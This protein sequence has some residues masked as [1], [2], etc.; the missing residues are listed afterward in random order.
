MS[1]AEPL[2]FTLST[3][4]QGLD[5]I[6][7]E[8]N[9]LSMQVAHPR[10]YQM[11]TWY[12][13]YLHALSLNERSV[14]FVTA[15]R[16]QRLVAMFPL[17]RVDRQLYGV[18]L[19]VLQF[20]SHSHMPLADCLLATAESGQGML[21]ALDRFLNMETTIRWDLMYFSGT[22]E[23]S[24]MSRIFHN[25]GSSRARSKPY[26]KSY[27]IAC[28]SDYEDS[29][30]HLSKR[31]RRNIARLKRKAARQGRLEYRTCFQKACMEPFLEEFLQVEQD[32]WKGAG[33][34]AILCHPCLVAFYRR[35]AM[36]TWPVEGCQINLLMLDGEAVAGQ[37]GL[38]SDGVLNL[39]KVGYRQDHAGIG[40][41]NLLLAG[42]LKRC[43]QMPTL[44][45]ISFVTAPAW[46]EKWRS[47]STDVYSHY[48]F[49]N[50]VAGNAGLYFYRA[51][52]HLKRLV[53]AAGKIRPRRWRTAKSDRF[54]KRAA[55]KD[56]T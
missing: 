34:T 26:G 8:W 18:P 37:F 33:N 32:G 49:N 23:D 35:L 41:G 12:G 4:L 14:H 7:D 52:P 21:D 43:D 42:M 16:G 15:R 20:P 38:V 9:R 40:P 27:S 55:G 3:G 50:T 45:A 48:L 17:R 56:S 30:S 25:S 31:F 47:Q 29:T 19:K 44:N 24:D 46:A 2:S 1:I 28:R 10:Y 6:R 22:P 11:P 5:D 39:L 51:K 13:A 36:D 54:D 53:S